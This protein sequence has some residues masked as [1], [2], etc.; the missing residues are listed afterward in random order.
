MTPYQRVKFVLDD[1]VDMY[2]VDDTLFLDREPLLDNVFRLLGEEA[3][4][5]EAKEKIKSERI[6]V[7]EKAGEEAA[8]EFEERIAAKRAIKAE[9]KR[10][11]Q[12]AHDKKRRT[13]DGR[14]SMRLEMET[15]NELE[16]HFADR[17]ASQTLTQN[18]PDINRTLT[19]QQRDAQLGVY[20]ENH[21]GIFRGIKPC[22]SQA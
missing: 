7:A 22:I 5:T 4:S 10:K 13:L 19:Q 18:P 14:A 3:K 16:R 17:E 20:Y 9:E 11:D 21:A 12:E 1:I 2:T 6:K 15:G 8:R